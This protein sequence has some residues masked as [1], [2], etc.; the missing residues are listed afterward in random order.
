MNWHQNIM[1]IFILLFFHECNTTEPCSYSY[2]PSNPSDSSEKWCYYKDSNGHIIQKNP[3]DCYSDTI[4]KKYFLNCECKDNC[5]EYY[6]RGVPE[7]TL[8][9]QYTYIMCYDTLD[10]A[11][12]DDDV[13]FCDTFQKTCWKDFPTDDTYYY[14]KKEEPNDQYR[15]VK[16]C[17]NFYI[18]KD[19]QIWCTDICPEP[20][21]H[22]YRG[23]NTCL[24]S[25]SD[26]YKYYYDPDNNECLDTCELRPAKPFSYNI[27]GTTPQIC[28]DKCDEPNSANSRPFHNYNSHICLQNCNDDHSDNIY[29]AYNGYICY[30]SCIDIPGALYKYEL[31]N[32]CH[33][34]RPS[35]CK[36]YY[37][38][39]NGIIKCVGLDEC[40]NLFYFHLLGD[41][42][43]SKCEDFYYKYNYTEEVDGEDVPFMRCFSTPTECQRKINFLTTYNKKLRRCWKG[44]VSGYFLNKINDNLYELVDECENFYYEVI[45]DTSDEK[46]NYCNSS[47]LGDH[48]FLS[49]N[50]KCVK[51][52]K[53]FNKYYYDPITH[54]C[55][56]S[57]KEIVNYR[58]QIK[59][60]SISPEDSACIA[61]CPP[62]EPYY[63]Y[64]S[65]ICLQRCGID[66]SSNKYHKYNGFICYPSCGEIPEGNF[67]YQYLSDPIHY[68]YTCY[69]KNYLPLAPPENCTFY[70][71]KND[72]TRV[73]QTPKDCKDRN[74]IYLLGD[75]CRDRCDEYYQLN[76]SIEYEDDKTTNFV[77]CYKTPK[78][79]QVGSGKVIYYFIKLKKCFDGFP[80]EYFIK[81]EPPISTEIELVEKCEKFYYIDGDNRKICTE[82]CKNTN[83]NLYFLIGYDKC[84]T[85]CIEYKKNFYDPDN[86]ECVDTCKGRNT[87]N[88]QEKIT[89]PLSSAS[90]CLSVC[91]TLTPYY[92]SDSNI[93]LSQCGEGDKNKLYHK[94]G[95]DGKICYSSCVEIPDGQFI[96]ESGDGPDFLCY[97]STSEI[98]CDNYFTKSDGTRRCTNMDYCINVIKYKYFLGKECKDSCDGYYKLEVTDSAGPYTKCFDSITD[99]LKKGNGVKIG[100][101]SCR[102]RV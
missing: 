72:G 33:I 94:S 14:F 51:S 70:Y 62:T 65:N 64:D 29:H 30:P 56:A 99:V 7:T 22:F 19:N 40:I 71:L 84:E 90:K 21:K 9:N 12:A 92:D 79:C 15:I 97:D 76:I 61:E 91:P 67:I 100:R 73:C 35:G 44:Y 82:N 68:I 54:E 46:R 25:C 24:S 95:N 52:C 37:I 63:N 32:E 16:S 28:R 74:Y 55:V 69:D 88:F 47:C 26:I 23:N 42:C 8:H 75:E 58:F 66:G 39:S 36:N 83:H 11:F 43:K 31:N 87:N 3:S 18:K 4:S 45:S 49:G 17:P 93:C 1:L 13:K 10:D 77:R 27:T 41:E 53:V 50:K 81:N 80:N 89:T 6:K 78:D 96:Y 59:L 57:C 2:C 60:S 34:D 102:E 48:F 5:Y 98:V 38:K 85:N 101:A 20:S 86:N